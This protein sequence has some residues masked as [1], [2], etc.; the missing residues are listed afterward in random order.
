LSVSAKTYWRVCPTG[1]LTEKTKTGLPLGV[2]T[3]VCAP[4]AGALA[5]TLAAAAVIWEIRAR[6]ASA[7]A[8]VVSTD[9]GAWAL[10]PWSMLY[11]ALRVFWA[12]VVKSVNRDPMPPWRLARAPKTPSRT[13][14]TA[15]PEP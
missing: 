8:G 12:R 11:I 15:V 6:R 4:T 5:L 14:C 3:A 10:T 13:C 9:R 2:P 1:F 7:T